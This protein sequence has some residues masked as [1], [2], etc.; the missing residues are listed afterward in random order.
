MLFEFTDEI[1]A[2]FVIEDGFPYRLVDKINWQEEINK[3]EVTDI[4]FQTVIK[5]NEGFSTLHPI[6]VLCGAYLPR[7]I[8]RRIAAHIDWALH[9]KDKNSLEYLVM[10]IG[11]CLLTLGPNDDALMSY[12]HQHVLEEL[13][14]SKDVWPW[15]VEGYASESEAIMDLYMRLKIE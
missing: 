5:H 15:L 11:P 14:S 1:N 12:D 3:D 6:S 2:F 7:S 10:D 13:Q 9:L 4:L 8:R